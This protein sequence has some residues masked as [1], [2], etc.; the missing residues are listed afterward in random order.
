MS[1]RGSSHLASHSWHFPHAFRQIHYLLDCPD[2]THDQ[3]HHS[4]NPEFVASAHYY[5]YPLHQNSH[6]LGYRPLPR[7]MSRQNWE[8]SSENSW[9]GCC[10]TVYEPP[11]PVGHVWL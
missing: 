2:H 9:R 5:R 8:Y 3:S 6:W 11:P 4:Y 10:Y 1:N 7:Y